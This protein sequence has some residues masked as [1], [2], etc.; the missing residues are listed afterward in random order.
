MDI[1]DNTKDVSVLSD[2]KV[3]VEVL[4][5]CKD[6]MEDVIDVN[7]VFVVAVISMDV[8]FRMVDDVLDMV[9]QGITVKDEVDEVLFDVNMDFDVNIIQVDNCSMDVFQVVIINN[10]L[11]IN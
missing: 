4:Q 3:L 6:V 9:F 10:A 5:A 1:D 7:Q 8:N 2:I 11:D